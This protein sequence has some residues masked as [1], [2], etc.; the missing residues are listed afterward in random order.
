MIEVE[1]KNLAKP[2]S[3]IYLDRVCH[4]NR[5]VKVTFLRPTVAVVGAENS[6]PNVASTVR[7]CENDVDGENMLSVIPSHRCHPFLILVCLLQETVNC[8]IDIICTS[9]HFRKVVSFK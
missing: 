6:S 8:S 5:V 2:E 1:P 9:R 4:L 7:L 3:T